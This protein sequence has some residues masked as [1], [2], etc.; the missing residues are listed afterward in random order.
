MFHDVDLRNVKPGAYRM[1]IE[2]RRSGFML[3]TG[4]LRLSICADAAHKMWTNGRSDFYF[5]VPEGTRKFVI[6]AD[7]PMTIQR[8]DGGKLD[9]PDKQLQ[10]EIEVKA[11]QEGVWLVRNQTGR[12]YFM[13][14]PPYVGFAP[15]QML[16]PETLNPAASHEP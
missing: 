13:G 11:G 15:Q 14:I 12:F 7:G 9:S 2:D 8:P 6:V 10:R 5:Y 4:G 1:I 16:A 3:K